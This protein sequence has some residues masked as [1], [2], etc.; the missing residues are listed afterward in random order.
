MS[1][2]ELRVLC[3][4]RFKDVLDDVHLSEARE[5]FDKYPELSA[6][7]AEQVVQYGRRR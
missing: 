5:D 6:E 1:F 2:A 3:G 4:L 7:L